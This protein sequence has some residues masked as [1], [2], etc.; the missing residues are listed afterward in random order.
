MH[1]T[2]D[3]ITPDIGEVAREIALVDKATLEAWRGSLSPR[4]LAAVEAARFKGEAGA[5]VILPGADAAGW[6]AAFGV[7]EGTPGKATLI[8]VPGELIRIEALER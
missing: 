4:A 1:T 6:S 5:L 7:P 3:Q 2:F 8:Q